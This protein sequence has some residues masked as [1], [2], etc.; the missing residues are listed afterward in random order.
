M[1]YGHVMF[2]T[3]SRKIVFFA[4]SVLA[5]GSLS[6]RGARADDEDR[7]PYMVVYYNNW[8][9][10]ELE[11]QEE[12]VNLAN[13]EVNLAR[14][15]Q[16]WESRAISLQQLEEQRLKT[17]TIRFNVDTLEAKAAEKRQ[18]YIVNRARVDNG[19]EVPICP[20]GT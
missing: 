12:Q 11:T 6:V 9:I 20:E 1:S 2:R 18:L 10:A 3:N 13:E 5:L 15:E 8:Q 17:D 19:L 14:Y 7:N 16:L 4:L